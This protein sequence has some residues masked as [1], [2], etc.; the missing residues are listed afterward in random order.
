MA[1][2]KMASINLDPSEKEFQIPKR[3]ALD[4]HRT[5]ARVR[6]KFVVD[7]NRPM[8]AAHAQTVKA[9]KDQYLL[10]AIDGDRTVYVWRFL[11]DCCC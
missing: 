8:R 5:E 3:E 1:S 4:D 11:P 6:A 9:T 10:L 7:F 2:S